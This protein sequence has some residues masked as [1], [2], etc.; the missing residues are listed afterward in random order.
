MLHAPSPAVAYCLERAAECETNAERAR[1]AGAKA[2]F[3][4]MAGNWRSLAQQQEVVE[5]FEQFLRTRP[6]FLN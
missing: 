3:K 1:N 5:R 4:R 6:A 2:N